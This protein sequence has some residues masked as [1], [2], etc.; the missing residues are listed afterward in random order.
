VVA[1]EPAVRAKV[2]RG[3]GPPGQSD[4]GRV[5]HVLPALFVL[6]WSSAFVAAVIGLGAA[7]PLLL[8]FA[9]FVTA[10]VLL[11]LLAVV[12]RARWPRGRQ[13]GHVAVSGLL[14]Q[15]L[16][17]GA[18]YTAIGTGLPGGVIALIQG[19]NPALIALFAA[20]VLGERISRRQWWGFGLGAAGVA[21]AV[22]DQWSFSATGVLLTVVGL[23]GLSGGT[24]YQK[25]FV[26]EIDVLPGTAV[27]FLVGAP[28]LGLATLLLERPRVADW[29]A[30]GAA[31]AWIVVVNSLG[32][33]VLLNLMLRRGAA[34]RVG[35]MFFLTPAVT[36]VLSW[37]VLGRQLTTLELAG[38][39]VGG[40]GVLLAVSPA[41]RAG[42]DRVSG[43]H[44]GETRDAALDSWLG[45]WV[46]GW[47]SGG[48]RIA[49]RCASWLRAAADPW[50]ARRSGS[51][52]RPAGSPPRPSAWR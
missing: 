43:R 18:T 11:A 8:T 27:Q 46:S 47:V 1:V 9:R 21:I 41:R 51:R 16:Q 10:G 32:T 20:P 34:S 37:L 35:T 17:F 28:V 25:R 24:V 39:A 12:T 4:G 36:A 26:G 52:G 45:G 31:L 48:G 44:G 30:F 19:L 13:L 15:A 5:G 23:L 14:I 42:R 40:V 6:L 50:A 22:L 7:P 29:P 33:F 3:G 2:E 38:L 49:A